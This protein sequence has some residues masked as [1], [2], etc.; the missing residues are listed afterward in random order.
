VMTDMCLCAKL[1]TV[2]VNSRIKC[3][4]LGNNECCWGPSS[5]EGAQKHV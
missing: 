3:K 5:F 4:K 1:L 2:A